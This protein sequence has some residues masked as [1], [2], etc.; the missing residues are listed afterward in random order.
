MLTILISQDSSPYN[1]RFQLL[2]KWSQVLFQPGR[3]LFQSELNEVQSTVLAQVK[4]LGDSVFADGNIVSGMS[5]QPIG[6]TSSNAGVSTQGNPNLISYS[7]LSAYNSKI[8]SSNF[9]NT[10]EV[11]ITAVSVQEDDTPGVQFAFANSTSSDATIRFTVQR[12]SGTLYKISGIFDKALKVESWSIDGKVIRNAFNSTDTTTPVDTNGTK[13][14]LSDGNAHEVIVTFSGVTTASFPVTIVANT[15]YNMLNE[16][17]VNYKINALKAEGGDTATAW[18]IA[19]A[20]ANISTGEERNQI[21]RVLGG[22]IYLG[23]QVRVFEQQDLNITGVGAET[24]GVYLNEDIITADDDPS[25]TDNTTGA[26]SQWDKG[27]DRLHYSVTLAYNDSNATTI[28][29]LQD[30]KVSSD[31]NKPEYSTLNDILAK[32]TMD[33]SGHY[34]VSG[35]GMWSEEDA[36]DDSVVDVL[37]DSGTAYVQGYQIIKPNSTTVKDPKPEANDQDA[38]QANEALTYSSVNNNWGVLNNQPV[39]QVDQ[40]TGNVQITKEG[41]N[42]GATIATLDTLANNEVFAVS[43]LYTV[44]TDTGKKTVYNQGTDYTVV[45]GNQIKWGASTGG[46][47]PPT[48]QTYYVDYQY[49]TVMTRDKDFVVTTQGEDANQVTKIDFSTANGKKPVEGSLVQISYTYFLARIDVITLDKD[50]KFTLIKGQPAPLSK[51]QPPMQIDPLTLKIGYV[52]LIPLAKTAQTQLSTTTRIPFSGL[53]DLVS[54]VRALEED[55]EQQSLNRDA[56]ASQDPVTL[57]NVFSDNFTDVQKA[58]LTN[59]EFTA[60]YL[61]DEGAI[62]LPYTAANA[63]QSDIQTTASSVHVFDHMVTAPFAETT[64]ISQSLATDIVNINPYQVFNVLGTLVI[65]PASDSWIES[66]DTTVN[67]W[68]ANQKI[69][70]GRWWWHNGIDTLTGAN[71]ADELVNQGIQ[72]DSSVVNTWTENTTGTKTSTGMKTIESAI[73]YIRQQTINFTA[74]NLRP[75]ADNLQVT[76]DGK[77][78]TVTLATGYTAGSTANTI[79]ADATGTVKG[80]FIIPQGVRTGTREVRIATVGTTTTDTDANTATANYSAQGTLQDIQ[81]TITRSKVTVNFSDPLAQSFA[82]DSA[83]I[84]TGIKVYFQSKATVSTKGHTSG[85]IV[86]IRGMG[87]EGYPTREIFGERLLMPDDIN[88]SSDSSVAT[89]VTFD[90]PIFVKEGQSMCFVLISDSDSYNMYKATMG[91]NRVDQP[92][93]KV[94]AQ[95][96]VNGVLFQS[97]NAYTWNA[98][99]DSDLKFDIMTATFN[100]SGTV[101]FDPITTGTLVYR[102]SLGTPI[103]DSAGKQIPLKTDKLVLMSSYLTPDNTGMQWD[104]RIVSE[105]DPAN[106]TITDANW[107]PISDRVDMDLLDH[108]KIIQLRAT[109][110]TSLGLSPILATDNLSLGA[111]L[112]SLKGSYISRNSDMTAYPFNHLR[113]QYEAYIPQ[114]ATVEAFFSIDGGKTWSDLSKANTHSATIDREFVRY[115]YDAQLYNAA[116]GDLTTAKQFKIRLDM[117]TQSSF[118]RPRVRRLMTSMAIQQD[119][120]TGNGNSVYLNPSNG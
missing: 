55:A 112:T 104:V 47:Q 25:L 76:F 48:G 77:P 26:V 24:L 85:V 80:S 35:F 7:T 118:L 17:A 63:L 64:A 92:A 36:T 78:V 32:R 59:E 16:G 107:Q 22:Y 87:D 5:L 114:G 82:F 42:R 41:V 102:D 49:S 91:Q 60:S 51:A 67:V 43:S 12:T 110:A 70:M 53:Q 94:N 103:L 65:D 28:Y 30:G 4:L 1:N 15:G 69:N 20:D 120:D 99:Q 88:V 39:K 100:D 119:N 68:G 96:Y 62:T 61:F 111:F 50:G 10:G 8:D 38:K 113:I 71:G 89:K 40:V 95:P 115:S 54:R 58:D 98:I 117:A 109:F 73:E 19:D 57:T 29:E 21:M 72:L 93:L 108:A 46:T 18:R 75:L 101:V 97:S 34:R 14:N 84:L 31:P 27:A 90:D 37:V 81:T 83:K 66:K 106:V 86:Q 6:T 79:R 33:E 13:I 2:N 116:G 45:N 105:S 9:K 23:G 56:M 3:P 44:A 52:T 74:S 11:D